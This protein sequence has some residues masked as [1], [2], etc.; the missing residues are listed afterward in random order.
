MLSQTCRRR[1]SVPRTPK[2]CSRLSSW[3]NWYM[4]P[5]C[6]QGGDLVSPGVN[7]KNISYA[8]KTYACGIG[9]VRTCVVRETVNAT[10]DRVTPDTDG[11][12]CAFRASILRSGW[13]KK[14]WIDCC[15]PEFY[16][17][18]AFTEP[19]A[20]DSGACY[21]AIRAEW[22]HHTCW[23]VLSV[24]LLTYYFYSFDIGACELAV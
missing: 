12:A 10:S 17:W 22:F 19:R 11:C 16:G 2:I 14:A 18:A 20:T 24:S 1:P 4:S 3:F 5:Q 7:S 23:T 6:T 8:V 21:G 9:I 13:A 15:Y